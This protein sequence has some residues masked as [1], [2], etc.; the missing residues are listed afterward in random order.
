MGGDSQMPNQLCKRVAIDLD[1]TSPTYGA[2][3]PLPE[4]AQ[5]LRAAVP[6]AQ[7]LTGLQQYPPLQIRKFYRLESDVALALTEMGWREFAA[8]FLRDEAQWPMGYGMIVGK[9]GYWARSP[10]GHECF[11]PVPENWDRVEEWRTPVW[12]GPQMMAPWLF[13]ERF[14]DLAKKRAR[15][16][17]FLHCTPGQRESWEREGTMMVRG[18]EGREYRLSNDHIGVFRPSDRH[19]FCLVVAGDA[20]PEEDVVLARKLLI[21]ANEPEFLR[22]ANEFRD[23]FVLDEGPVQHLARPSWLS[24]ALGRLRGF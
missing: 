21:E 17:L 2:L 14:T 19:R 4:R 13:G 7:E 22:T 1:E 15:N 24:R 10:Q 8:A 6:Q 12:A 20:V 3:G 5:G 18:S 9:P 16:L 11:Y 23:N